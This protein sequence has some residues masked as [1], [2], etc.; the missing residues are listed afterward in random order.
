MPPPQ[1]LQTLAEIFQDN[2]EVLQLIER[3]LQMPPEEQAQAVVVILDA[4]K[5]GQQ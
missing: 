1:A 2:P 5:G 4:I 3:A